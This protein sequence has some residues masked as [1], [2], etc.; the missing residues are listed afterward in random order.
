MR[1]SIYEVNYKN[2]FDDVSERAVKFLEEYVGYTDYR[3][4]IYISREVLEDAVEEAKAD[5]FKIDKEMKALFLALG[6]ELRKKKSF[7]I[8]IF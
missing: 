8:T 5:G 7:D 4:T 3:S 2:I 6:K 1:L